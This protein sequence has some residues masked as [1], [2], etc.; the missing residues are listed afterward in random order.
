MVEKEPS[1]NPQN[2]QEPVWTYRGYQLKASEFTTSMIHFFRAE[3]SR[4]NVWRMRL[5]TAH[6]FPWLSP[7]L[8]SAILCSSLISCWLPYSC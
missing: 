6:L 1:K 2:S 7:S 5:D 3:V 4:A 8:R